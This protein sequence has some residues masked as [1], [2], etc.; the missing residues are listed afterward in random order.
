MLATNSED[1]RHWRV[2]TVWA[3]Q[4]ESVGGAGPAGRSRRPLVMGGH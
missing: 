4:N 2:S 3:K 1:V